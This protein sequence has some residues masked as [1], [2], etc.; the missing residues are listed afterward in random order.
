[1]H[2]DIKATQI[3]KNNFRPYLK[4]RDRV[5]EIE[6]KKTRT[7][8]VK[9]DLP[10]EWKQTWKMN[11][12]RMKQHSWEK[13]IYNSSLQLRATLTNLINYNLQFI[14]YKLLF[15]DKY[16]IFFYYSSQKSAFCALS[17]LRYRFQCSVCNSFHT[18]ILA[19]VQ[20]NTSSVKK[21][22]CLKEE[23]YIHKKK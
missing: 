14:N 3:I 4:M 17:L 21:N 13:I 16:A 10:V 6:R 18:F 19:H 20:N 11:K 15:A 22:I 9:S 2:F 5:R 1:M 12:V 7:E 23:S 8:K